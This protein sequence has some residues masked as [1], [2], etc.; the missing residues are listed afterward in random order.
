MNGTRYFFPDF[1]LPDF[2]LAVAL[3]LDAPV[4]APGL[5]A[6]VAVA[7]VFFALFT[8]ALPPPA[9]DDAGRSAV[10]VSWNM[11]TKSNPSVVAR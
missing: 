4:W 10:F 1:P 6:V 5:R 3:A 11:R 8:A 2:F 9:G 7:E